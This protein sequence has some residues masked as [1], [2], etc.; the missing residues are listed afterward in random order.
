MLYALRINVDPIRSYVSKTKLNSIITD[1]H[2]DIQVIFTLINVDI[3]F[4]N[5]VSRRIDSQYGKRG[6]DVL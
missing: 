1:A 5:F 6:E 3:G 2:V 4:W